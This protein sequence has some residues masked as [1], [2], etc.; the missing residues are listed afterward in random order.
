MSKLQFEDELRRVLMESEQRTNRFLDH[1]N[2]LWVGVFFIFFLLDAIFYYALKAT[3]MNMILLLSYD[4]LFVTAHFWAK[5]K[6]YSGKSTKYVLMAPIL[7]SAFGMTIF[8]EAIF[9]I[10]YVAVLMISSTY[11][12]K[13]VAI[14]MSIIGF[15]TYILAKSLYIVIDFNN[16]ATTYEDDFTEEMLWT[17]IPY[18]LLYIIFSLFSVL[19]S[20]KGKR[21]IENYVREYCEN[22]NMNDELSVAQSI[23]HGTLQPE[24]YVTEDF[25]IYAHMDSAKA[26]G[27][28]FYDY[29]RKDERYVFFNIA[30]VSGKGLPASLFAVNT[31]S[32]LR[33]YS[34]WD[35]PVDRVCNT[36]NKT[37]C[38][39]NPEKMFVTAFVGFLDITTGMVSYV[40][41]GHTPAYVLRANGSVEQ[42]C[43]KP[44]FVL[45]R[46]GRFS[47]KSEHIKLESGDRL[48]LYTDGITEAMS[49]DGT[50][51]GNDRLKLALE[52]GVNNKG[53][54]LIDFILDKVNE[55][56]AGAEQADDMTILML[57]YKSN[58]KS[59]KTATQTFDV[60]KE[61]YNS[62]IDFIKELPQSE[63]WSQKII[64][65]ACLCTDETFANL[66][67][68]A[69]PP[70]QTE[71]K[72]TITT[73]IW[74]NYYKIVFA[75][76]GMPFNPLAV[77]NTNVTEGIKKQRKKG[78]LGIYMVKN[79][80]DFTSYK[81]DN[82]Q[83]ILTIELWK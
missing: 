37:L 75:D 40:N 4:G 57:D 30:D 69:F 78:G 43:S 22:I 74:D 21:E 49:T 60:S 61:N 58:C 62:I 6:N 35:I 54:A 79:L 10:A 44:N 29:Y 31:S 14:R 80:A 24:S 42:V 73:T 67:M 26:V 76:N 82:K 46:K 38:E 12:D 5:H 41:A 83:N 64:N 11:N 23:Q 15:L 48:F 47:Y 13:K 66:D 65:N 33:A 7:A 2:W 18:F 32:F 16:L 77:N 17:T 3:I 36:T 53:K 27:G 1:I 81:F 39:R 68:Y 50:L 51:F 28:D 71:R 55:F 20:I 59:Y 56:S 52:E 70:T 19:K 25:E 72:L 63:G 45:G 9:D 8:S 34:S